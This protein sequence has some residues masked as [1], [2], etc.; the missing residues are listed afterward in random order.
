M[1]GIE[2]SS[3]D[4]KDKLNDLCEAKASNETADYN[5]QE[6]QAIQEAVLDQ[7]CISRVP[8]EKLN[9][10][11]DAIDNNVAVDY[12]KQEVQ[13]I[14]KAVFEMLTRIQD[15]VNKRGLFK[16][17]RILPV[18]SMAEKTALL[19]RIYYYQLAVVVTK[20]YLEF[21]F[22]A[23]L[24]VPPSM[25]I[26]RQ[27]CDG[28]LKVSSD[29]YNDIN[30]KKFDY[31]PA[32]H[33]NRLF[34][35]ELKCI[36]SNC[37]CCTYPSNANF[38]HNVPNNPSAEF[39]IG[40]KRCSI[41]MSTGKLR[42]LHSTETPFECSLLFI[43]TSS[44]MS[45]QAY[46]KDMVQLDDPIRQMFIPVDFLPAV[47]LPKQKINVNEYECFLVPKNCNA[48]DGESDVGEYGWRKSCCPAEIE[49]LRKIMSNKHR[50]CYLFL[51]FMW[52][53]DLDYSC[54][55]KSYHVK[56][57]VLRHLGSCSD[58]SEDCYSCVIEIL[59]DLVKAYR[60]RTL[61]PFGQTGNMF[62]IVSKVE[63]WK[64]E[65]CAEK[66]SSL[67]TAILHF[68]SWPQVVN[69]MKS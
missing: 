50:K 7:Q 5:N 48:C 29:L 21:D 69:T 66:V 37:K 35:N 22:L 36:V 38:L 30:W 13:D 43:W 61:M 55:L 64:L 3:S 42:I 25:K 57:V 24:E 46:D 67:L 17:S 41:R 23:I 49:T 32:V 33:T 34:K 19:C 15:G 52:K 20:P 53:E 62:N 27:A 47:E 8:M 4:T 31:I 6:R 28:C 65:M 56:T 11:C 60:A 16:V 39:E 51:K 14:Q 12:D 18:G 26:E 40:C 63:D 68:K 2:N 54:L 44:K 45:L 1:A 58:T 9:D 10:F 59:E